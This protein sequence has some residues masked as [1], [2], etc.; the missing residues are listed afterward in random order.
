MLDTHTETLLATVEE[1]LRPPPHLT[2]GQLGNWY[3][4]TLRNRLP[5]I[6]DALRIAHQ[7]GDAELATQLIDQAIADHPTPSRVDPAGPRM[8]VPRPAQRHGSTD[9]EL[10]IPERVL[11]ALIYRHWDL[12]IEGRP[13]QEKYVARRPLTWAGEGDRFESITAPTRTELLRRLAHRHLGTTARIDP[14]PPDAA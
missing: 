7:E 3:S 14:E 6:G 2:P 5:L 12:T 10:P 1:A 13:P 11:C 8:V 9:G 4:H